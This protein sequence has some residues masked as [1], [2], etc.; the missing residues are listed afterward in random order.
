MDSEPVDLRQQFSQTFGE[1]GR[2]RI[3]RAPGRVNLI[4]EHTDY[5]DGFVLP[6]AIEPQVMFACRSRADGKVRIATTFA[7]GEIAEFSVQEKILRGEPKWA[8]YSRGV[9]AQLLAAGIPL[10]G[11]DAFLANTL[12]AGG[13]LSSSAA[14]EVGTGTCF[15]TLAGLSMDPMRLALL[16]QKAEHEYAGVPC[17]M[18]DQMIVATGQAG[19]AT[20]FDCR[21]QAKEFVPLDSS[22]VRVVVINSMVK[23]ELTGGEYAERRRQCELGVAFFHESNPQVNALRDISLRQLEAAQGQLPGVIYRRCRHIVSENIRTVERAHGDVLR[24]PFADPADAAQRTRHVLDP[25]RRP[26]DEF[27]ADGSGGEVDERL[28]PGAGQAESRQVRGFRG[29]QSCG[30]RAS[31]PSAGWGVETGAPKR[32]ASRAASVEAPATLIC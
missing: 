24:G 12:P 23:H 25:V 16:C 7:P 5:N 3:I 9:A 15:L 14:I 18:M 11:M 27:A 1:A 21:S 13:G 4:G 22:E 19:K 20:L 29:G 26:E 28:R 32:A 6:M 31:R 8:N 30:G 10:T 2:I 17:G